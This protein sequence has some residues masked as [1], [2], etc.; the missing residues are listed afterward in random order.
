M[1]VSTTTNKVSYEGNGL[2]TSFAIPFPFLEITDLKVYQLLEDVQTERKD[3]TI[4]NGNLIFTTAP[5]LGAQ[6]V[7]IREVPL[8][9]E[10]DYCENE[11]LAAET[12]ERNFDKLTMLVQQLKE[13]ADRAVT[14]DI[15]D[16]TQGAELLPNIR[17]AVSNAASYAQTAN[18][19]ADDAE[20]AATIATAQATIATNKANEAAAVLSNK[21]EKDLSN[22]TRPYVTETYHN[23]ND[24]Y[25][26]W[27]DGFIEQGGNQYGD[28]VDYPLTRT[29]TFIKP[30]SS[31]LC[32]ISLGFG[33]HSAASAYNAGFTPNN[34]PSLTGFQFNGCTNGA[35]N[36]NAVSW[37][38]CGF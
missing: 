4:Q 19:K 28:T 2:A 9:Q 3:W 10:T 24:W 7:I 6:I 26:V 33:G 15:F 34:I 16:D 25:R 32:T 36:Q 38:A 35:S 29:I 13:Q 31:Y 12:L 30:F 23:G 17:T 37:Y 1:T 11:I 8:K 18:E 5:V 22:C 27:S 21:A 14:V 20:Q